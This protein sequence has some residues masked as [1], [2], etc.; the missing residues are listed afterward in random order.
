MMKKY[1]VYLEDSHDVYRVAIPAKNEKEAREYVNGNGEVIAV[2]NIT[3]D[4]PINEA[5]VFDA[6]KAGGFGEV[7]IDLICRALVKIGLTD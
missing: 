3:D 6:L 7:E 1:M 4:Y 2:K 5:K